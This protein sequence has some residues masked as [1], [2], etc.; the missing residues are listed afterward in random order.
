MMEMFYIG[1]VQCASHQPH[2][3]VNTWNVAGATEEINSYNLILIKL[4]V[5][6]YMSLL[7]T[8]LT[9]VPLEG[10]EPC[11]SKCDLKTSS[12]NITWDPVSNAES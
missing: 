7:A 8:I 10:R 1:A 4:V 11:H 2:V 9:S 5:N 12:I 3:L 6:S